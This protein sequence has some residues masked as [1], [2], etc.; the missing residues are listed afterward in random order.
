MGKTIKLKLTLNEKKLIKELKDE[1]NLKNKDVLRNALWFYAEH[2]KYPNFNIQE[3]TLGEESNISR[4]T[5]IQEYI[6]YL[7]DEIF[8]LREENQKIQDHNLKFQD[9]IEEE[10]KRLHEQYDHMIPFIESV[11]P[12]N[13]KELPSIVV[14]SIQDNDTSKLITI[15]TEV[16]N[17]IDNVLEKNSL[18][19][20]MTE[21]MN[22]TK[23]SDLKQ[24]ESLFQSL[25]SII[26]IR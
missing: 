16:L 7:K 15:D 18:S 26:K 12:R 21:K 4:K 11:K 9:H 13:E 20:K 1:S 2:C 6:T 14:T 23:K 10:I 3:N 8:F 19:S 25:F 24:K 17:E 22:M 5:P